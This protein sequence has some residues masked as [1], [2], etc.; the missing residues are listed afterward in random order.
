MTTNQEVET[1]V[2]MDNP[3]VPPQEPIPQTPATPKSHSILWFSI[4]GIVLI[5][6][7]GMVVYFVAINNNHGNTQTTSS[8]QKSN[9][10]VEDYTLPILRDYGEATYG[11]NLWIYSRDGIK[12]KKLTS[13]HEIYTLFGI[14]PDNKNVLVQ[15]IKSL[16]KVNSVEVDIA[17]VNTSNG[18]ITEFFNDNA[19]LIGDAYWLDNDRFIYT[20]GRKLKIYNLLAKSGDVLIDTDK[21]INDD[22][23][24]NFNLS[25]NKQWVVYNYEQDQSVKGNRPVKD[26]NVYS[27]S[28]INKTQIRLFSAPF[29]DAINSN[30][31]IYRNINS[32]NPNQPNVFWRINFDGSQNEILTTIPGTNLVKQIISTDSGDKFVYLVGDSQGEQLHL[33]DLATKKDIIFFNSKDPNGIKNLIVSATAD[34]ALFSALL[35]EKQLLKYSLILYNLKTNTKTVLLDDDMK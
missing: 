20:Q 9:N 30:F 35:D 19:G 31:V 14:S 22:S 21:S 32:L 1:I 4:L 34:S 15:T 16:P 23:F 29:Y 26:N 24:I 10:K 3:E 27:Y 13:G 33:L 18:Q 12:S 28:L 17:V 6:L 2:L 8:T 25:P 11:G 5:L 7:I